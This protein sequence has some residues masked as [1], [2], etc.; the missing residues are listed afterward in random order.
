MATLPDLDQGAFALHPD[1]RV[2]EL[3]AEFARTG[4]ISIPRF[5]S[6][7][8]ALRL[9]E[10]LQSR[11]DWVLL[12]NADPKVI[13]FRRRDYEALRP[14]QKQQLEKMVAHGARRGFQYR[15]EAIAVKDA[16]HDREQSGSLLDK[17]ALFMSS[18]EVIGFFRT[19]TGRGDIGWADAQATM[20]RPGHF[21]TRHDDDVKGTGRRA[22]YVLGLTEEWRP[23]WG[24]LLMFHRDNDD[25]EE[26]FNPAF[27]SLRLF[28][29]PAQHSV[30]YVCPFAPPTRV[31]VTGWLRVSGNAIAG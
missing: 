23:E 19:L 27:N 11:Q 16:P 7:E 3:A 10:H 20:Y 21:L 28:A 31:A 18:P 12:L 1:L 14:D 22:A 25:I 8:S 29:V 30:S 26:A 2:D 5:L 9:K 15:Y 13:A 24:G 4:R 6:P 17:F